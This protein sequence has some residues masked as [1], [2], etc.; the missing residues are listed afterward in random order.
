MCMKHQVLA[1]PIRSISR[2]EFHQLVPGY[3]LASFIGENV[4]WFADQV[5][6]LVGAVA[7]G[8]SDRDWYYVVL[9]RNAERDYRVLELKGRIDSRSRAR[10]DL[11]R[12]MESSEKNGT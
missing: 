3:T 12:A 11:L 1:F 7:K 9:E 2:W 10:I 8:V 6:N 5:E 4:E